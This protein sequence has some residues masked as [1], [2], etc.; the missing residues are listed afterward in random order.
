MLLLLLGEPAV[1]NA[2]Q[3]EKAVGAAELAKAKAAALPRDSQGRAKAQRYKAGD[4]LKQAKSAVSGAQRLVDSEAAKAK[5][6]EATAAQAAKA[7]AAA[8]ASAAAI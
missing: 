8:K 5:A 1:F 4:Q 6:L 3:Q 2:P 7:A